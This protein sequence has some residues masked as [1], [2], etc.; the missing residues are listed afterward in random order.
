[1]RTI[2][3]LYDELSDAYQ[4]VQELIDSG[5]AREDI[6][7][8]AGDLDRR[9]SRYLEQE[10]MRSPE[11]GD[12]AEG[13]LV[14]GAIGSLAGLLVGLG[15]LMIP[16][17]GPVVAVGSLMAGLIGAIVGGLTGAIVSWGVPE[18]EARFY[19]EA[20]QR[21]ATLVAVR[22]PESMAGEVAAI[23]NRHNPVDIE[24]RASEWR[25]AGWSDLNT[26]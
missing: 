24:K 13:A 22:A 9:Y 15:A 21:G 2:V 25:A 10:D 20:V 12:E 26:D 14:G 7:L 6:G 16:G 19:S 5:I 11:M 8:V 17:V 23:I 18:T 1:M 3:G 4:A